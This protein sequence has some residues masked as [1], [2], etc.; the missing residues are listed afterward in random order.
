[1]TDLN[2]SNLLVLKA[3]SSLNMLKPYNRDTGHNG[4]DVI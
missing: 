3:L 1:M 2:V 4:F